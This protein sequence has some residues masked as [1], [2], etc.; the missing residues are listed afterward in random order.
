MAS[1]C[2]SFSEPVFSLL[3]SAVNKPAF[4]ATPMPSLPTLG[5]LQS[6]L[7]FHTAVSSAW[8]TSCLGLT[9][10]ARGHSNLGL[11]VRKLRG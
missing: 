5:C 3:K 6:L 2:R 7:P 8:L 4:K 9:R 1:R 10:G 11:I